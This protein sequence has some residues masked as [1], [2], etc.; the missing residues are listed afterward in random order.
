MRSR[1]L[2]AAVAVGAVG[3]VV[4][5]APAFAHVHIDPGEAVQGSTTTI[6]FEVPNEEAATD[7]VKVDVKFPDDHPIATATAEPMEG[8]WTA[9]VIKSPA[10]NV[11]E[12]VWT[13][14]TIAPDG[15][16]SFKV[17]VGPLPADVTEL[18]FPTIQTYSDG[19]EVAW[20]EPTPASGEEPEHPVPTLTLTAA[21]AGSTT[22]PTSTSVTVSS[23]T[24]SAPTSS[25]TTT[26]APA[27]TAAK[28]DDDSKAPLLVA[29][30]VVVALIA[31]V[32]LYVRSRRA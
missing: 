15:E 29:A 30:A 31:G 27:T 2:V 22:A 19:E 32:G 23:T 17:T 3:L 18:T 4:L 6:S 26:V 8:G 14:G 5:A 7:T 16:G 28:D 21:P 9:E 25:T 10:G 24:T 12:I 13:G 20:I 1:K 11:S